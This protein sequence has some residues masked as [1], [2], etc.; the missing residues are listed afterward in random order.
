MLTTR[1]IPKI[2][3]SFKG[4]PRFIPLNIEIASIT[5][6]LP[7]VSWIYRMGYCLI[8]LWYGQK[9]SLEYMESL[10]VIEEF[11]LM[12]TEISDMAMETFDVCLQSSQ[13]TFIYNIR[14]MEEYTCVRFFLG[15]GNHIIH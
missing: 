10:S 1:Y 11:P 4:H 14:C 5:M 7:N 15:T 9:D 6:S 13:I 12:Q 8:I 3:S 2:R